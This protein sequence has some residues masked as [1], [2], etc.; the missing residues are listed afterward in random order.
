MNGKY[1]KESVIQLLAEKKREL[2]L[3]G[4]TE[5]PK[6]GDFS[7]EEVAAIKSFL[8]PWPRALEAAGVKPERDD[9]F[10]ERAKEKR[11]RSKQRKT[12]YKIN[13]Q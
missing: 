3:K 7:E 10:K 8:G 4:I 12:Q 9:G 2:E 6:K 13:K 5:Y 11:I 1:T